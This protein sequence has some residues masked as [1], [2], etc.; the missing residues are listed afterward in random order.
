M[1]ALQVATTLVRLLLQGR[2]ALVAESL[3]HRPP[4]PDYS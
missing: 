4:T 2:V 1:G 3:A